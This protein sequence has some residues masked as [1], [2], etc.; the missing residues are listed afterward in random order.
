MGQQVE[1]NRKA[2]QRIRAALI[3][4]AMFAML[5]AC[6]TD[7]PIAFQCSRLDEFRVPVAVTPGGPIPA[8]PIR[9]FGSVMGEALASTR[10]GAVPKPAAILVLSGGGKWGAYGAGLLKAWSAQIAPGEIRP[11]FSI[12]TGVSTGALQSTFAFLG[13][14][15]DE[16]LVQAYRIVREDQL[17]KRHGSSFFISHASMADLSPLRQYAGERVAPLLDDVAREAGRGRKLFVG[18]IDALDGKMYAIDLT[19]I[20]SE[21]SGLE[22]HECYVGALLASAAIPVVFRQV[23]INNK[24]YFD[25]G[26]RN[27]VFLAG[28][29]QATDKALSS[30]GRPGTLWV[31]MNGDPGAETKSAVPAKLLPTLGRL[32]SLVFD[33]IEQNSVFAVS[34]QSGLRTRIATAEGHGCP[35]D[36]NDEDIFNPALMTCLTNSGEKAYERGTPWKEYPRQ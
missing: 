17:A 5:A 31:L 36:S 32:R 34:V 4:P 9:D 26:V 35:I 18:S 7:T 19:R 25:A 1:R 6:A 8:V 23:T 24:P 20:A 28:A 27:S 2:W 3:L 29:R 14:D 16:N 10:G 12:V 33:Q 22:R 30:A 15:Y 13:R 21:L 11:E